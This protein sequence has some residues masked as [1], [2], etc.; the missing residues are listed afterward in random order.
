MDA[1]VL[2]ALKWTGI[3][4]GIAASCIVVF[5][6]IF[7]VCKW[8]IRFN[9]QAVSQKEIKD[10]TVDLRTTTDGLKVATDDLKAATHGLKVATS[11]L[12][13]SVENVQVSVEQKLDAMRDLLTNVILYAIPK[14]KGSSATETN[15]PLTLSDLRMKISKDLDLE[16]IAH[17]LADDLK[18]QAI[19]LE[20]YQIHE[21]SIDFAHNKFVPASEVDQSIRRYSYQ[22]CIFR[23]IIMEV[24]ALVLRDKLLEQNGL[25]VP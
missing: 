24:L 19:G 10:E 1:T 21:L 15:S 25:S 4:L 13:V 16:V 2:E 11:E 22:E 5:R 3:A 8:I 17:K 20:D 9:D 6:L 23:E 14:A 18:E 12:K 7:A